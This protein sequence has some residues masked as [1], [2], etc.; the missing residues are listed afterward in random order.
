MNSKRLKNFIKVLP[1]GHR[2][3]FEFRDKSW[4]T[5][6]IYQILKN[7]NVALCIYDYKGYRSPEKL[8]A[9]FVYI[10]L[11][12]PEKAY[13][14]SYDGRR[15]NAYAKKFKKWKDNGRDVFCY[16]DNDQKGCAPHDAK[17]LIRKL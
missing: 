4:L 15:L 11:H 14:G 13:E 17:N 6:E 5:E 10:R 16:F 1:S 8:T 2:Y 12:G 9:D 7:H 3:T